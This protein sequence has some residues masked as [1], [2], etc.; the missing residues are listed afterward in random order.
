MFDLLGQIELLTIG[1][2]IKR[3]I[4]AGA[5]WAK[6]RK[7]PAAEKVKEKVEELVADAADTV[8]PTSALPADDRRRL[9]ADIAELA[10]PTFEQVV[11]YSP[12]TRR[13]MYVA[14][15]GAAPKKRRVVGVAKRRALKRTVGK[16]S[17][18]I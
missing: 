17:K 9:V 10:L 1:E 13:V 6:R 15:K 8:L 2:I 7:K 5:E 4:A 12:N 14:K 3:T 18:R 16:A 11:E